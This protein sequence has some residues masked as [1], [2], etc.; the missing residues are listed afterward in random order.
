MSTTEPCA[1]WWSTTSGPP[2]TS[3][4]YLLGRT[5]ASARCTAATPP[6]EALRAAPAAEVDVVFL[7]VAMPGLTGI[8]LA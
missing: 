7:D 5:S 6:T 4:T 3:S 1:S 8:E 2:S